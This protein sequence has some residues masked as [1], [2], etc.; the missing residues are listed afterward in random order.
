MIPK[1]K[2]LPIGWCILS[3]LFFWSGQ[4]STA[5]SPRILEVARSKNLNQVSDETTHNPLE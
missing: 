2:N 1:H 5:Q 4:S 3:V